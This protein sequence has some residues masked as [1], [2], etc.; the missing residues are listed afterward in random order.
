M[1]PAQ[2]GATTH[3]ASGNSTK[4]TRPASGIS[5]SSRSRIVS[6]QPS[7]EASFTTPTRGRFAVAER[8]AAVRRG[9]AQVRVRPEGDAGPAPY[10][11]VRPRGRVRRREDAGGTAAFD[12]SLTLRLPPADGDDD[13]V[14]IRDLVEDLAAVLLFP[15]GRHVIEEVQ[16]AV[17]LPVVYV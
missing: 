9:D 5:S 1:R 6:W 7:H 4:W 17:K 3:V 12:V 2:P 15:V 14:E 8:G 10:R 13:R 11:L 16:H